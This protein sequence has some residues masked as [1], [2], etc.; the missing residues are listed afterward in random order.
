[1]IPHSRP[2]L[3]PEEKQAVACVLESGQIA[4][5][6][7]VIE[8]EKSFCQFT[9]RRYAIA[10]SSGT[11][12]LQLSL[13][14]LEI[15]TGDEVIV[16]SF[17]CAALLHAVEAAGARPAVVDV[18]L[19]DFNLSL[20]EI[21]KKARKKTKAVIVPHAFGLAAQMEKLED[22]GIPILEDGTQALGGHVGQRKVGSFGIA[23]VF[24]FYATKMITTGEGG[25]VLTNS[26]RFADRLHD[27]RDY[28]KKETHRFRTNSK[29]TDIEAAM[30]IEQLKKLEQFVQRRREIAACY[31]KALEGL[32]AVLPREGEGR[33]SVYYRY[34]IRIQRGRR[35]FLRR[36][37]AKGIEAKEPIFKPLHQYLGLRD[38][39]F[40]ATVQAM[41][42]SCSLP[43]YPSLD[44]ASCR[45]VAQAA[46][47]A[48]LP[49]PR[50]TVRPLVV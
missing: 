14:A 50:E 9:G 23:S 8:F 10:V 5:G 39:R 40:P 29:M 38:A 3:G 35:E 11:A 6:E 15:A 7:K 41:K 17:T 47:E 42:E 33:Q 13:T 46:R 12:A 32:G 34:V 44:D 25:M 16:P 18:C 22:L 48:L 26:P 28:D 19:E 27:L 4:Q 49:S 24:S 1:M 20:S 2:T 37:L 43:I 30:G 45:E 31:Q 21:K 36:L